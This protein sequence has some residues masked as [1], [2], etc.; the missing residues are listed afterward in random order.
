M[1]IFR[2]LATVC[3]TLGL[4]AVATAPVGAEESKAICQ[5]TAGSSS[6]S[7]FAVLKCAKES[8][9]RN[10]IIRNTIFERDDRDGYRDLA[11]FAGRSFNCTL[12]R[13]GTSSRGGTAYTHYTVSECR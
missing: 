3:G 1:R 5:I 10:F 6:H 4:M 13:A 8:S 11:R 9:P 7:K 12:T 2:S